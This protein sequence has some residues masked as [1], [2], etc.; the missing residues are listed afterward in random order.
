[1]DRNQSRLSFEDVRSIG[2]YTRYDV[3]VQQETSLIENTAEKH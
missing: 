3:C 2:L 1:M